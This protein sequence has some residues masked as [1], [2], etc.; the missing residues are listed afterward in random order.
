[1]DSQVLFLCQRIH[2]LAR[3][4]QADNTTFIARLKKKQEKKIKTA[5][6]TTLPRKKKNN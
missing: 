3:V 2:H 1:M 6:H 5:S 4:F